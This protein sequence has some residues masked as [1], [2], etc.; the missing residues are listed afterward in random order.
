MAAKVIGARK[1]QRALTGVLQNIGDMSAITK[2]L[3]VDMT[4]YAHVDTGY[5]RGTIYHKRNIAGADA[6]YAGFEADRGKEHDF[7]QRAID[8]FPV[9]EYF[10]E[11]VEPF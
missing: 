6:P 11:I 1:L 5:M 8:A 7:A 2:R 4:K 3:E 10:D 9:E